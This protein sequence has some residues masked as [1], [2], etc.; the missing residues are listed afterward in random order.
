MDGHFFKEDKQMEHHKELSLEGNKSKPK[1]LKPRMPVQGLGA[2]PVRKQ[3]REGD[4]SS[5]PVGG[6]P[7][8][9]TN[10]RRQPITSRQREAG[11]EKGLGKL[12][13][14]FFF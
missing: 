1:E 6:T 2:T 10:K 4:N 13:P 12:Q 5:H 3:M 14:F 8:L 11:K 7:S 9:K